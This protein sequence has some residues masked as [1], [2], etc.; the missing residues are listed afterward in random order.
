MEKRTQ[1]MEKKKYFWQVASVVLAVV[2]IIVGIW[3]H[4]DTKS[5]IEKKTVET[6]AEYF[7]SVDENMSYDDVLKR[8]YEDSKALEKKNADLQSELADMQGKLIIQDNSAFESA[9]SFAN[10]GDYAKAISV[11]NGISNKTAEIQIFFEDCCKKHEEQIITQ[12]DQLKNERKYDEALT[13]VKNALTLIPNNRVLQNKLNEI[14]NSSPA[15]LSSLK[16]GSSRHFDSSD[17]PRTDT[18]GNRYSGN[19]YIIS[20]EGKEGY[21]SATYYADKKH[22]LLSGTIAVSDDSENRADSSLSG[23][24]EILTKNGDDYKSVYVSPSLTRTTAP[25][26]LS[27]IPIGHAEWVEIRYYNNGEY[28][29]LAGGNHSLQ[30]L[31]A[32]FML[33]N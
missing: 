26:K 12:A 15:K 8:I 2:A 27:D 32:D 22:R 10:L 17:N 7:D 21:G 31:V 33:Y 18:T 24:I 13:L 30:I 29:S 28:W 19:V 3:T 4:L 1:Q 16:L 9:K 11:L 14:E 20:A 25:I 23:Y 6:L 5:S